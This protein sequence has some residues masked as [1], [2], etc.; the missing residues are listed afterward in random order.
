MANTVVGLYEDL[1]D[2]EKV[3]RGLQKAGFARDDISLVARTAGGDEMPGSETRREA[4]AGAMIGGAAGL[5]VGLVALLI[6]GIGP[7]IAAGPL[8]TALAGV[9]VGVVAGGLMGVLTKAGVPQEHAFTYA[10]GL[11][12]GRILVMVKT[13]AAETDRAVAIMNQYSPIEMDTRPGAE[14][15]ETERERFRAA[16]FDGALPD[17]ELDL[18]FQEQTFEVRAT[19]EELIVNKLVRVVEEVIL[20]KHVEE[21]PETVHGTVRRTDVETERLPAGA[22]QPASLHAASEH[23]APEHAASTQGV[24]AP[25]GEEEWRANHE[26]LYAHTGRDYSYYEPHY[27]FGADL[28]ALP[29]FEG[30]HWSE[31]E[32]D[33]QREWEHTHPGA[34]WDDFKDVI[35]YGWER[36]ASRAQASKPIGDIALPPRPTAPVEDTRPAQYVDPGGPA[37]KP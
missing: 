36:G 4:T 32:P 19:A 6:P 1:R 8:A 3:V 10:E 18:A 33:A 27:R 28:A 31:I 30:R 37:I 23:A 26:L 9:G 12:Q 21:R 2:A 15:P 7:I 17:H 29:R 14:G 35:R 11:R 13:P 22:A 5:V 34:Y 20:T 25:A 24:S 16:P